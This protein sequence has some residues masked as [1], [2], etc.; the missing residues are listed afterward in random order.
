MT[1]DGKKQ[2]LTFLL[3]GLELGI[4]IR[5]VAQIIEHTQPTRVP[6]L[7]EVIRGVIN[8]RGAVL[9]VVDL[10]IK[11]GRPSQPVTRKTCIV[12]VETREAGLLGLLADSVREVVELGQGD[13]L[14]APDFGVAVK[15]DYLLGLGKV[16]DE[17]VLLID[18]AKLLSPKELM[19]AAQP[20]DAPPATEP[21]A[22]EPAASQPAAE[23]P[24]AEAPR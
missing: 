5:E 12:I 3:S 20:F 9:P 2:Y 16:R 4:P 22:A 13:I 14:P 15:T 8:L 1:D 23:P 18:S 19:A 21:A 7:P 6:N 11:L 17:L 10:A 24:P